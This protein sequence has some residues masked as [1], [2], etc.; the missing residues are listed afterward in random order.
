MQLVEVDDRDGGGHRLPM[1]TTWPHAVEA[2]SASSVL[3]MSSHW[4][5]DPDCAIRRVTNERRTPAGALE[6]SVLR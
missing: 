4:L 6:S 1:D 3:A 2:A 5:V